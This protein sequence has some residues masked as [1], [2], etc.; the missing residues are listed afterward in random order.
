MKQKNVLIHTCFGLN[1][2]GFLPIPNCSRQSIVTFVFPFVEPRQ[3][4]LF[5]PKLNN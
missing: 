1:I 4:T 2:N 5:T 3:I